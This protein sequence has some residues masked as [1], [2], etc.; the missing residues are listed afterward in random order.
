MLDEKDLPPEL[1]GRFFYLAENDLTEGTSQAAMLRPIYSPDINAS[2]AEMADMDKALALWE[3]GVR[4]LKSAKVSEPYRKEYQRELDMAAY[5]QACFRAVVCGNRFFALKRQPRTPET[6]AEMRTI[7]EADLINARQALP[8]VRR[9]PSLDLA[10][11]MDMDYPP[12]AKILEAKIRYAEKVLV[13]G[14]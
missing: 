5:L 12:L 3:Q 4:V 7:V 11:R 2:P 1:F 9:N 14:K 10:V 8:I 6:L 13:Q